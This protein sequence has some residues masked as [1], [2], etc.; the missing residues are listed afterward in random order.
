MNRDD[1]FN[2]VAPILP[3]RLKR[4]VRRHLSVR[5]FDLRRRREANPFLDDCGR[6]FDGSPFVAVILADVAQY[7]KYF[8]EACRARRISYRVLDL[9]ADGWLTSLRAVDPDVV[10]TWPSSFGQ[11]PK[12]AFDTRLHF[13][14]YELNV[15]LFPTWYESWLTENKARQRDWFLANDVPTPRSWVFHSLDEA[16]AVASSLPLPIVSKTITGASGQGV[17]V[18]RT[19]REVLEVV[20]AAFGRGLTVRSWDPRDRLREVVFLQEY[21]VD[22]EEW[23]MVRIGDG[24]FG[25][26]KEKGDDGRHSASHRWSWLDPGPAL[27]GFLRDVTE[28]GGFRSMNV[29]VFRRSDGALVANELHTVFGCSTPAIQ[30]KVDGVEGRYVHCDGDWVFE[31]GEFS[32]SHMCVARVDYVRK[33]FEARSPRVVRHKGP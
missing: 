21:L 33:Q 13:I 3:A 26:R 19:R 32:A 16:H 28:K 9:M 1:L 11:G 7:H 17:N 22:A 14:E 24:Y 30:M 23:R 2:R 29:D 8:I 20:K 12:A 31:Q 18:L 27:L 10:F 4:F 5:A 25:Y 6:D 15:P